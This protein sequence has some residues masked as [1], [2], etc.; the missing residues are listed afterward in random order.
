MI[1]ELLKKIGGL[2]LGAIVGLVAVLLVFVAAMIFVAVINSC[3]V[4]PTPPSL[5]AYCTGVCA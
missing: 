2:L 4:E 1:I 3:S 5:P